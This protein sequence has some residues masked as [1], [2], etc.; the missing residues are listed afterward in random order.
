L[1][2]NTSIATGSDGGAYLSCT[3]FS[4]FIRSTSMTPF[5]LF[6]LLAFA[7]VGFCHAEDAPPFEGHLPRAKFI[8]LARIVSIEG[9][10]ITFRRIESLRGD[11]APELELS[12]DQGN[13]FPMKV[14]G[15]VLL[16]SQGDDRFGKP[17]PVLDRPMDGLQGWRGWTPLPV[18]KVG[19]QVFAGSI[20]SFVDGLSLSDEA[21]G[22]SCLRLSRI[23]GLIR[24]FPYNPKINDHVK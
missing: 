14:G 18:I 2:Q 22:V 24:R 11:P 12:F 13:S 7:C 6:L 9:N 23:K 20:W 16:F 21:S 17:R 4:V 15:E 19:D 8:L 5:R 3:A 1:Q 10:M